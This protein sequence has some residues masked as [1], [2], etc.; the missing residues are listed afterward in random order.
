MKLRT[1]ISLMAALLSAIPVFILG[2]V[3]IFN[4]QRSFNNAID[5][6][7]IATIRE[8]KY[9]KELLQNEN[10]TY[11][12]CDD[13]IKFNRQQFIE[14]MNMLT[15]QPEHTTFPFVFKNKIFIGGYME[16]KKKYDNEI[17]NLNFNDDNF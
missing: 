14:E 9:L 11:V 13:I 7:L 16:T 6:S 15:L 12:N 3:A 2:G 5:N 10:V 1:Q 4:A 17:D 8:P